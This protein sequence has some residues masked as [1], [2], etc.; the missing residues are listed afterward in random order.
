MMAPPMSLPA[1][2]NDPRMTHWTTKLRPAVPA[3][4]LMLTACGSSASP[5]SSTPPAGPGFAM[6]L[7]ETHPGAKVLVE[8]GGHWLPASIVQQVGTDLFQV[9]FDGYGAEWDEVVGPTRMRA[10][11]DGAAGAEALAVGDSVL[12]TSEQ[13]TIHLGSVIEPPTDSSVRVRYDGFSPEVVQDVDV[14]NVRRP[15]GG[16]AT[17]APGAAVSVE[18]GGAKAAGRVVAVVAPEQYL[19]RFEQAGPSYDRVFP[20][21][22]LAAGTEEGG[23]AQAGAAPKPKAPEAPG[24]AAAVAGLAPGDAVLVDHRGAFH[25]ATVTKAGSGTFTVRYGESGAEEVDPQRVVRAP[26]DKAPGV[27][28]GPKEAVFVEWHGMFFKGEVLQKTGPGQ[29]KVRFAGTGPAEDEIVVARRLR[30]AGPGAASPPQG[31]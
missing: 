22:A 19:V 12:V 6:N 18:A 8:R 23:T 16:S 10:P 17:Y 29:Y 9:R 21:S 31:D 28:Y 15:H 1:I 30:P 24:K 7:E 11:V 26:S 20:E 25:P 13:G 4:F 14:T 5:A 3:L 2:R 27:P